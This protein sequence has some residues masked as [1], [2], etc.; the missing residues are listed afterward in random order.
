M[1]GLFVKS[2]TKTQSHTYTC[3]DNWGN[4]CQCWRMRPMRV[5]QG[6]T[7]LTV[8]RE[9]CTYQSP[10]A[11]SCFPHTASQCVMMELYFK[12]HYH[13][14]PSPSA[15]SRHLLTVIIACQF[16]TYSLVQITWLCVIG[17]R[18]SFIRKPRVLLTNDCRIKLTKCLMW[19]LLLRLTVFLQHVCQ[20]QTIEIW[21]L[22]Y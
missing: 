12:P 7:R 22:M 1:K 6:W 3:C 5:R 9:K 15:F 8:R 11:C 21:D 19:M 10:Q 20:Q 18:F 13:L 4:V 14:L 2:Y 17:P 16:A